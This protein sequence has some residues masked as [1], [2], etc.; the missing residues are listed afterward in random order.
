MGGFANNAPIVTDGLV[1]YVDAGNGLSYPS[2]G[3][4]WNDLVGG[5]N[6]SFNNM[7][8]VNNPSNNYDSANGG[9]IVFDG[10]DDYAA[11][12]LDESSFNFNTHS[13]SIWIK[14]SSSTST[15]PF[16]FLNTGSTT[17]WRFSINKIS[18]D[19]TNDPGNVAFW[20]RDPSGNRFAFDF[21]PGV[22]DGDWHN[23]VFVFNSISS[24]SATVYYD[25]SSVSITKT[26]L[27]NPSLGSTS[28][29]FWIGGS[30]NRGSLLR[31][32]DG[33]IAQIKIYNRA[34]SSTEILQ[35]Y[36]ALKNRFI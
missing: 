10:V 20:S 14:I 23:I 2:S 35:N 1:F 30:N 9:S 3:G 12:L 17:A 27:E 22:N 29:P 16:G 19:D 24:N 5:N 8:D 26:R 18:F 15:E 7:D 32:L 21:N 13:F 33:N 11:T 25:G 6:G 31:P 34:L 36:N 28:Y 4:T